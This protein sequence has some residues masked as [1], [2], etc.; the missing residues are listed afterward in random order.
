MFSIELLS[1]E[2]MLEKEKNSKLLRPESK[3]ATYLSSVRE[4][5][6]QAFPKEMDCRPLHV[7]LS[8]NLLNRDAGMKVRDITRR[9]KTLHLQKVDVKDEKNWGFM[10][11]GQRA[12]V[13]WLPS[14]EGGT[15]ET[16]Q[17]HITVGYFRI[18]NKLIVPEI[19]QQKI[20]ALKDS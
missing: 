10:G 15:T 16:F 4:K 20:L 7:D 3:L 18:G 12:F 13:L 6:K 2:K 14:L 1:P 19:L 8:I 11:V 5:L 9:A 17:P